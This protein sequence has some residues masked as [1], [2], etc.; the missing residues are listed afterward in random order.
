MGCVE[1]LDH[2]PTQAYSLVNRPEELAVCLGGAGSL[3]EEEEKAAGPEA[4]RNLAWQGRQTSSCRGKNQGRSGKG[5][6]QR[7]I[8]KEIE[9]EGEQFGE[10]TR[11]MHSMKG[12]A[13]VEGDTFKKM[14]GDGN[15]KMR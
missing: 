7:W 6:K 3:A 5:Y 9:R 10:K 13:T 11:G 8:P 2:R 12:V 15:C 1:C 14:E 4:V